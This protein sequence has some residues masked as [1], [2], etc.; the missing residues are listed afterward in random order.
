MLK[1]VV[2]VMFFIINQIITLNSD[3]KEYLN[4][5]N[6]ILEPKTYQVTPIFIHKNFF[7]II[8]INKSN[9]PNPK[10]FNVFIYLII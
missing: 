9:T 4:A 1:Y 6:L 10:A 5:R 7:I 2:K 8:N 3:K